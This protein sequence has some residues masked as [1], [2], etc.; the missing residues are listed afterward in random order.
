MEEF[1]DRLCEIMKEKG[2]SQIELC[3]ATG[4][5]KSA[6]SQ[7]ISGSFK[8]KQK[9]TLL[10]AEA[11]GVDPAWLMGYDVPRERAGTEDSKLSYREK[12]L[13]KAYRSNPSLRCQIDELL[14][15]TAPD[16]KMASV[17]RAANS[18]KGNIPAGK[19]KI[20][21]EHLE[22]LREAPETDEDL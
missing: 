20:D 1:C 9:R 15:T 14:D 8:P 12:E 19:E 11:L 16:P 21:L 4:I 3:I 6:L 17:F 10:L 18:K 22:L 13:V 2:I 7:Y 5:S